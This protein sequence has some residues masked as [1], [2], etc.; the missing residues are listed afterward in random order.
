MKDGDKMEKRAQC[1]STAKQ[2][3]AKPTHGH[4]HDP[5][6]PRRRRQR[7][8]GT[9]SRRELSSRVILVGLAVGETVIL[10]A[11]PLRLC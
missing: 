8:A 6:R 3:G 9:G 11:L 10:L 1:K 5:Q 2:S 7:S 4:H